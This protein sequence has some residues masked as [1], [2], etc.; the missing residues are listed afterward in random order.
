MAIAVDTFTVMVPTDY[1]AYSDEGFV[2]D[3]LNAKVDQAEADLYVSP[4]GDNSNPGKTSA[5]PLQT[6]SFALQKILADSSHPRTI[7]LS[8]GFY[9]P[10]TTGETFPLSMLSYVTVAGESNV[11]TILDA[12]ETGRVLDFDHSK[13]AAAKNMTVTGG[14]AGI[15]GG[16]YCWASTA[17]FSSLII[18]ENFSTNGAGIFLAESAATL[19]NVSVV[20]NQPCETVAELCAR[21]PTP[22]FST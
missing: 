7:H 16:A 19:A 20:K 12:E 14:L 22:D 17:T 11:A 15:G 5:E 1:H 10:S 9:S 8:E 21:V 2:F 6:V 13:E 18:K 4:D 3:I